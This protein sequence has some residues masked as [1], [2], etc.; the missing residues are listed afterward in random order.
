MDK[1]PLSNSIVECIFSSLQVQRNNYASFYDDQR[2]TWSLC[3]D[4]DKSLTNFAKQVLKDCF[5]SIEVESS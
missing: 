5:V 1:P 2:Q 3:F 4:S